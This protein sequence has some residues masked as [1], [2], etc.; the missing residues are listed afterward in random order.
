MRGCLKT[1]HA[2]L[3]ANIVQSMQNGNDEEREQ[4]LSSS[5]S[6]KLKM[7]DGPKAVQVAASEQEN[8]GAT[9]GRQPSVDSPFLVRAMDAED[10]EA[11]V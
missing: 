8:G 9:P 3:D 7:S 11:A 6:S 4:A 10:D 2:L 5:P 1:A